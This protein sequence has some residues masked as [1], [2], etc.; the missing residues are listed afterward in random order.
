MRVL[1]LEP[2]RIMARC[3]RTELEKRNIRVDVSVS[4][5]DAVACADKNKPDVVVCELSL[6]GHSGTEFMYEF[7]TYSDWQHIPL[8]IFSSLT[9]SP[10]IVNCSDWNTLDIHKYMYKSRTDVVQLADEVE[11]CVAIQP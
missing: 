2:D 10:E 6:S 3:I 1:L 9:V 4:A 11:S 8:I 5:D 7:R